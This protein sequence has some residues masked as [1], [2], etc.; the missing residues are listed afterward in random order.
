M[1]ISN[2]MQG[3]H[4]LW[5]LTACFDPG[6]VECALTLHDPPRIMYPSDLW[7]YIGAKR[8]PTNPVAFWSNITEAFNITSRES[9]CTL[10]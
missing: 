9:G 10:I 8:K 2:L 6:T 4:L 7:Q 1:K 5:Y 3:A